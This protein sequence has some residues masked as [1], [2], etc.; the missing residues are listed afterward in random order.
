VSPE[1]DVVMKRGIPVLL[2]LPPKPLEVTGW[3]CDFEPDFGE[4]D[5]FCFSHEGCTQNR[6]EV[7]CQKVTL[8]KKG[9]C[10]CKQ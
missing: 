7:N 4:C 3:V 9:A 1:C 6:R 10:K 2:I 8:V 5:P